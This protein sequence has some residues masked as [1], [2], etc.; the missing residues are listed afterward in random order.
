MSTITSPVILDKTGQEIV[1]ALKTLNVG[2][3]ADKEKHIPPK[4][5]NFYDFDG[6]VVYAY[7]AEEFLALSEFPAN[8]VHEGLTAQGWNWTFET[9]QTYV[10][11]YGVCEI[12]QSYITDDGKT[13]AVIEIGESEQLTAFLQFTQNAANA[14][15]I[16]WG[17]GTAEET[18]AT[19]G[20]VTTSH[21]YAEAGIYTIELTVAEGK[22]M[23]I[24]TTVTF[25]GGFIGMGTGW[26]G[27]TILRELYIG[28][29]V[30]TINNDGLWHQTGALVISIP[31]GVTTIGSRGLEACIKLKALILPRSL[32]V[33]NNYLCRCNY[34]ME[35]LCLP[36]SIRTVNSA[37]MTCVALKRVTIPEGVTTIAAQAFTRCFEAKVIN[38]PDTVRTFGLWTFES[39]YAV[40]KLRIPEGVTAIPVRFARGCHNL[41]EID[42][43]EGV[44]TIG[45][46]AFSACFAFRKIVIP[47]TVT[48][49]A[50]FAFL[51]TD[52]TAEFHIRATTPPVLEPTAFSSMG[53][54]TIYVPYSEDHSV[55][56]AY[57]SATGWSGVGDQIVEEEPE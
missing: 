22:L 1:N 4:D 39:C 55:L 44:T 23:G 17:D 13:R 28:S 37:F 16:N 24:G 34:D 50:K 7:T 15:T 3:W 43:P 42:I 40:R 5:V 45:E 20:N 51:F 32:T 9:A 11:K 47:S 38:I 31:Y 19:S 2:L 49:I 54:F 6:T 27:R 18:V 10:Q 12:G 53:E 56:E 52:G 57:L 35:V 30:T 33:L 36:D 26:T 41:G 46:M 29:G 14:V 21:T 8:P 48:S 25:K